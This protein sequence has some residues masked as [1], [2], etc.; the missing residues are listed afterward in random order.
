[1]EFKIYF[2]YV[3]NYLYFFKLFY[4]PGDNDI[5]GEQADIVTKEKVDRFQRSFG[6]R[7]KMDVKNLTRLIHVNL[8]THLTPNVTHQTT[9]THLNRIIITH[10]SLLSYPG[11]YSERVSRF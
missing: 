6:H 7:T 5:G 9:P 2:K 1:M 4:I 3:L 11:F 10:I 8:L